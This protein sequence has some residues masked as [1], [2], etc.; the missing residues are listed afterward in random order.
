MSQAQPGDPEAL[1]HM[2]R[3]RDALSLRLLQDPEVSLVDIGLDPSSPGA[4]APV[5]RVHVRSTGAGERLALPDEIEGV[6]VRVIR[7]NYQLE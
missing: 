4:S 5:I 1:M 6:P 7:A 2:R 3:V